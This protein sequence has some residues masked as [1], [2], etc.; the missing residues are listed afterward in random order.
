MLGFGGSDSEESEGPEVCVEVK[1]VKPSSLEFEM[2]R[3]GRGEDDP[4][5]DTVGTK[6]EEV[7]L[8]DNCLWDPAVVDGV[9]GGDVL[10][11]SSAGAAGDV[12]GVFRRLEGVRN[13][14]LTV[15]VLRPCLRFSR[16]KE[17]YGEFILFCNVTYQ[18]LKL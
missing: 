11:N 17:K 1:K 5:G 10:V 14:E 2:T 4:V 18:V 9:E 3:R 8:K 13:F 15:N 12:G 16:A 6:G 7:E